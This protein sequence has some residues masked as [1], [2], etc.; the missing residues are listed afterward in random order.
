MRSA[1]LLALCACTAQKTPPPGTAGPAEAV[2]EFSEA[3]RKGDTAT[4]CAAAARAVSD[5][6]P[7]N[8]QQML[9]TSALPG[10]P[11]DVTLV[12]VSGDSAEVQTTED[13]GPARVWRVVREGG[14]WRVD[15]DL[16]R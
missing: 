12:S 8:G 3:L 11:V 16:G 1:L 15:L 9:F 2:R 6:G 14:R 13:G 10:R 4:A 5:A 7:E